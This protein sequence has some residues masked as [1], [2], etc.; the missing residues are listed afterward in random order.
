MDGHP[1]R[2]FTSVAPAY[3]GEHFD[4][5]VR[6]RRTLL[7]LAASTTSA[8]IEA[9]IEAFKLEFNRTLEFLVSI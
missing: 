3:D 2:K 1:G 8:T 6:G 5:G 7:S 9:M 4:Y